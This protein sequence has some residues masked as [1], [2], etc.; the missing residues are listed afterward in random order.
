MEQNAKAPLAT[1]YDGLFK[2]I[3]QRLADRVKTPFEIRLWGG[4]SFRFGEGEP[5]VQVLVN[6]RNGLAA[7]GR[8]DELG[9]CEAYMAG[10]LDVAGD[11]MRFVSLRRALND[12]HPLQYLWR[13]IA[14]WF[15]GR[16]PVDR[17]AIAAHYDFPSEFYLQFLD[18]TRC[19]SQAVFERDDEALET[20]QRRKLDFAID[21][22]CLKP[23]D[24]VLDV[25]GG[26][27][28]FTE[29]AGQRGIQVTSLTISRQSEAFLSELIPRAG[30]PCRVLNQDFLAYASEEP[31]DAMVI[32]GVMEHLPDYPA[33]LRQFQRLLKPGGHVYLDASAFREKHVKPSFIARYVFPADHAYFCLHDFLTAAA[34]T[35]MDVLAVHNDRHS[36][37]LTCKA[38]AENLEAARDEIIRRWGDALYRRFRLYLWGSAYAFFSRGMEAFRVVLEKPR[39][40]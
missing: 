12:S 30:L 20:A 7:L 11:M 27:G 23:G 28:S 22:C 4:R 16:I 10:S 9:I 13:R 33:V 8:F 15:I 3:Q 6:D 31:Y 2:R 32:L 17:Q 26:W 14:P 37:Y 18:P 24:R 25:G 19:Y 38:W 40:V 29:Y 34:K 5:A 39:E 35:Q 21:A 1:S 36:Y